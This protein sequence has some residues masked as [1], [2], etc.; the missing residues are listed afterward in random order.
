MAYL[1][2]NYFKP[3]PSIMADLGV[4]PGERYAVLRFN[5]FDAVH[6]IG[7]SGFT[8]EDK[9]ELV[10]ELGKHARVFISPEGDLPGDLERYRL[11]V[12]YNRIHSVLYYA[13]LLVTDTQTMTTEAAILGSPAVRCNNFV[14]P[15]DAGNFIELENKYDLIYSFRSTQQAKEKA[16][17]LIR[18]D[19]LKEQWRH[20]SN[21]LLKDKIDLTQFMADFIEHFPGSCPGQGIQT[22]PGAVSKRNP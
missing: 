10:K 13:S 21:R 16:I 19:D 12:N 18:Q 7:R 20:K 22:K 2:P 4:N 14:G 6:D 17:Q 15:G 11:P 1:H 8:T 3:D 5:I 9:Y